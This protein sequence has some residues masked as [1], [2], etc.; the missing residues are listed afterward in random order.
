MSP[1][2]FEDIFND[3]FHVF[4]LFGYERVENDISKYDKSMDAWYLMFEVD[5]YRALGMPEWLA[6]IW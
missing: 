4:E 3:D 5:M 2:R 1:Q 6:R